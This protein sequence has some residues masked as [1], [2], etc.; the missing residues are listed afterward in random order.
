VTFGHFSPKMPCFWGRSEANGVTNGS[1]PV[2]NDNFF[3][4]LLFGSS[5]LGCFS[6]DS[7]LWVLFG[8]SGLPL[9]VLGRRGPKEVP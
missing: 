8:S 9:W 5:E 7:F 1:K 3:N 4:F 2:T 6:S